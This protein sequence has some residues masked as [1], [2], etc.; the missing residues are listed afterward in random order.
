MLGEAP[1]PE[2]G[3]QRRAIAHLR[4]GGVR[5]AACGQSVDGLARPRGLCGSRTQKSQQKAER[6]PSQK[7]L[8]APPPLLEWIGLVRQ[9]GSVHLLGA[10]R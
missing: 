7:K 6:K 4:R 1:L 9:G 8:D 10:G 2:N 3:F 5:S